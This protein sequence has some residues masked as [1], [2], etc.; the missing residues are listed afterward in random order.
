[1]VINGDMIATFKYVTGC[2]RQKE[3][4]HPIEKEIK[5]LIPVTKIHV[6]F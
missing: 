3:N 6:A 4:Y 5:K 2:S 1:M